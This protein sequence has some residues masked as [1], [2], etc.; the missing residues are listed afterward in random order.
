VIQSLLG[1]ASLSSTIV[2]THV[3]RTCLATVQSP[4]DRLNLRF[5]PSQLSLN[6][7]EPGS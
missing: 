7:F 5:A 1:H 4:L 6:G 2:Y 3:S